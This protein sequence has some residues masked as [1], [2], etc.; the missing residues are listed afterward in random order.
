MSGTH[1]QECSYLK[2]DHDFEYQT[3]EGRRIVIK[4]DEKLYLIQKTNN[5]WWKVIRNWEQ[6]SFYVPVT[7]VR[8]LGRTALPE[9][10][11]KVD[12]TVRQLHDRHVV[13][14]I[15]EDYST[16][17]KDVEEWLFNNVG[18]SI[19]VAM[20]HD[21][22]EDH[23]IVRDV[24]DAKLIEI[25]SRIELQKQIL[26]KIHTGD[27]ES[28]AK[29]GETGFE[30]F[31]NPVRELRN[32]KIA[33]ID[34]AILPLTLKSSYT[35]DGQLTA[36]IVNS[37]LSPI[38]SCAGDSLRKIN[39]ID[40]SS[41]LQIDHVLKDDKNQLMKH[42][43]ATEL[44]QSSNCQRCTKLNPLLSTT[45]QRSGTAENT[46]IRDENLRDPFDEESVREGRDLNRHT[47]SGPQRHLAESCVKK[48]LTLPI[49]DGNETSISLV[50]A[51]QESDG[52]EYPENTMKFLND[53]RKSW[54]VQELMS[55][56]TQIRKER[57]DD[58][59]SNLVLKS[60]EIQGRFDPLEKLTQELHDLHLSQPGIAST[61]GSEASKLEKSR[62]RKCMTVHRTSASSDFGETVESS[63]NSLSKSCQ[64]PQQ[65]RQRNEYATDKS[66]S[67]TTGI[68]LINSDWPSLNQANPKFEKYIKRQDEYKEANILNDELRLPSETKTKQGDRKVS[69]SADKEHNIS[70]YQENSQL[71][72]S[73]NTTFDNFEKPSYS[74]I[75]I[76][77]QNSVKI[78]PQLKLKL[79][80]TDNKIRL[81][82]S[83]EKLANEIQ[84]LPAIRTFV[85]DDDKQQFTLTKNNS[86]Q[87]DDSSKELHELEILSSPLI[88][89]PGKNCKHL[90][91]ASQDKEMWKN[92][93]LKLNY[94]SSSKPNHRQNKEVST[95]DVGYEE[96]H[97]EDGRRP[98]KSKLQKSA[99][100]NC[101]V[102]PEYYKHF[103]RPKSPY[104]TLRVKTNRKSCSL[105][106]VRLLVNTKLK[107]T[108]GV[109]GCGGSSTIPKDFKTNSNI[110][111][112]V[113]KP[114]PSPPQSMFDDEL[115]PICKF[116]QNFPQ[117]L[118]VSISKSYENL[119]KDLTNTNVF[120]ANKSTAISF[121]N[122][123]C[124]SDSGSDE[125]LHYKAFPKSFV[126]HNENLSF[127]PEKIINAK[128]VA[129]LESLPVINK[130][131]TDEQILSS[132]VSSGAMFIQSES[133]AY[134]LSEF[135]DNSSSVTVDLDRDN[136]V[137]LPP[138]WSQDYDVNSKQIC[139]VN[140][141]GERWFSSNDAEGK[142]YFFAEN[143]N[144]SSWVLPIITIDE[145][146][147]ANMQENHQNIEYRISSASEKLRFG[148]ARSLVV[149]HQRVS[150]KDPTAR[151][152]GSI[153]HDWPQ[154]F[155]GNMCILKEGTLQRTKITE[156]GKRLRKNWSTSY[157]VLS[158][159]FLLF[160]KD[161]K[162][163]SAMKSGQSVTAKPDIS[164]DLNGAIVE[165]GDK[166]SSR[167]N[168]YIIS[169]ILGLQVLIQSDNITLAN[170]WYAEIY[171]VIN[172][173]PSS[174]DVQTM[175]TPL[176]TER[177]RDT[178]SKVLVS[179]NS[180]DDNQHSSK[181]G[182]SRSVKLKKIE[183]S[184]E[185]LNVSL[186]E[187]Q[188]KIKA[189]LKRF[190]QRRPTMDSLVKN[191][192]Y[193]DEPAFGSY[194][195]DVCSRE[196]PMVPRFVKDCIRILESNPENMKA[197]GLYRASGNLSQIQKIRLQV[198]QNNFNILTQEED[199]HV[200]TGA[201]KLFFRELKEPLIPYEFFEKAL[202]ASMSK[203]KFEKV[204][205]FREIVRA[206]SQ[207][208]Y[209][210]LQFLLQHLLR[211]TL[212]Q[213]YNRM[214]IP[215][216]AIVFGPTLMWPA[217]ES[218]NMALDL[219]QQNLVIE[220]LLSEYDK[221]FK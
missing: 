162:A 170:E 195:K 209:D 138:G 187:R 192:I 163:F 191:G 158:E 46:H 87:R 141:R 161:S 208:H 171:D 199:V 80:S 220:C 146:T 129:S 177:T 30:Q 140:A 57:V 82:P 29:I 124:T 167:K 41:Q 166:A 71:F 157:V 186:V 105:E 178:R 154:L 53:K 148:K 21:N 42:L 86:L 218:A 221:I 130:S 93:K 95:K 64:I 96:H 88:Q 190:F 14:Q 215:N 201:L 145:P 100:F 151:R 74:N 32:T 120:D 106:D 56:L 36:A 37:K 52:S 206:L 11:Y 184:T 205:T 203:K 81:T 117:A 5:D 188:T 98:S 207:T 173:L 168:V 176:T 147:S 90:M 23:N 109:Q 51:S 197:D 20:G 8:E 60:V 214:H 4:K 115:T 185:D 76:E 1:A 175:S 66:A 211:V 160:F 27:G 9:A 194:L 135:S 16:K 126:S 153:S 180:P 61:F 128:V 212:Y 15:S 155:D 68:P 59:T 182:R 112:S 127:S 116:S 172:N 48:N 181:I 43:K 110:G 179:I 50:S 6:R 58:N 144:E 121:K 132:N 83:L 94:N 54:A 196:P 217:V 104:S 193:K 219:M 39:E 85:V 183:G 200:L 136:F 118:P 156:N 84:F 149:G 92:F 143:S 133:E 89:T 174:I 62:D 91:N 65:V 10:N 18:M 75:P 125:Y 164:V 73:D 102:V 13:G 45:D 99:T 114:I 189:K 79:Q 165:P 111:K 3:N 152:S 47:N 40:S 22:Q 2:V 119:N 34:A 107:G 72:I 97:L 19:G 101:A 150:I 122:L 35:N 67:K 24:E 17:R 69:L 213:E 139:F 38:S 198:D 31:T 159:L 134:A 103:Q 113:V 123:L 169:T 33:S 142:I 49:C 131:I 7:Y 216:L 78:R 25:R 55:E 202:K 63:F 137:N 108:L 44:S 204:Q 210:T 26:Q 28:C 77:S 70:S 12:K